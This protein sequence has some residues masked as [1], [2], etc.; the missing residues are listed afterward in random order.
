LSQCRSAVRLCPAT[1][2]VG[3]RTAILPR[4]VSMAT[5]RP[6]GSTCRQSI[7]P[8]R[9]WVHSTDKRPRADAVTCSTNRDSRWPRR[10]AIKATTVRVLLML[11]ADGRHPQVENGCADDIRFRADELIGVDVGTRARAQTRGRRKAVIII[12]VITRLVDR[13]IPN[14]STVETPA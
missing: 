8:V 6:G 11:T 3:I 14:G 12:I 5:K 2:S 1:G 9:A 13:R 10:N 4:P 7:C